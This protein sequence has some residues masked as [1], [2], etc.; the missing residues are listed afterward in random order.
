[1]IAV[2]VIGVLLGAAANLWRRSVSFRR[3][4]KTYEQIGVLAVLKSRQNWGLPED[5]H[6]YRLGEY[7]FS[8]TDKYNYAS[9]HPWLPVSPDPPCPEGPK[10]VLYD[11]R[12]EQ[13][14]PER[15]EQ[16]LRTK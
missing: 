3:R 11:T 4:A 16:T 5:P 1:M 13:L 14:K 12:V 8:L 15:I 2:A 7:F 6:Y 9:S 10:D